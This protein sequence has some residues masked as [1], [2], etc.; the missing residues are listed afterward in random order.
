[1]IVFDRNANIID[2]APKSLRAGD[3]IENSKEK[4]MIGVIV[5]WVVNITITQKKH[6]HSY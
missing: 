6:K 3:I 1:M 2:M 4:E 5:Y